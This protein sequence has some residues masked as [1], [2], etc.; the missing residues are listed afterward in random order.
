MI[1]PKSKFKIAVIGI[2]G[3]GGYVGGKLAARFE[4]SKDI[5]II[6]A[7]RGANEKAIRADG[8]KLV[9]TQGE[10]IVHPQLAKAVEIRDADLILLCTKAYDLEETLGEFKDAI[11][12]QTAILPLLNGVEPAERIAQILPTADV[13]Q[14]CI[15]VSAKLTEPG[16]IKESA[17]ICIIYFGK[18]GEKN[19]KQERVENLFGEAGIDARLSDEITARTW[20]KFVFISSLAAT[21]TYLNVRTR[22][23][24]DDEN[25]KK[26]LYGLLDEVKKV[27]AA[28]NIDISETAVQESFDKL[29]S[30]PPEATSSMHTDSLKGNRTEVESL[31]GYV[32]REAKKLDV[33]TPLYEKVYEGLK[34][35]L[36]GD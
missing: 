3:V 29:N 9:T 33:P 24:V 10:Q 17:N 11:S 4:N 28:K 26:L 20:D 13:W 19:E 25:H 8:L 36:A 21:T 18:E 2:G 7:A 14:G 12:E 6:L 23:V 30:L 5:E 32:I 31:V 16:V 34:R 22:E 35:K 1:D 27:A 15:Y